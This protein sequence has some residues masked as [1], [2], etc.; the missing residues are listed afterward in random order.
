M[1]IKPATPKETAALRAEIESLKGQLKDLGTL[2]LEERDARINAE[3]QIIRLSNELDDYKQR[4]RIAEDEL[5][6]H[7]LDSDAARRLLND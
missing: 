6:R 4:V 7:K 2:S 3:Q 5:A 1:A